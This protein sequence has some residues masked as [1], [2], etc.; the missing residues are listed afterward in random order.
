LFAFGAGAETST[1]PAISIQDLNTKAL[2]FIDKAKAACPAGQRHFYVRPRREDGGSGSPA[3]NELLMRSEI[4]D[5][6]VNEGSRFCAAMEDNMYRSFGDW[7]QRGFEGHSEFR[8]AV[9]RAAQAT[10]AAVITG[11]A[12]T[13]A[14]PKSTL[15]VTREPTRMAHGASCVTWM[16]YSYDPK[17]ELVVRLKTNQVSETLQGSEPSTI[18]EFRIP[19]DAQNF[20]GIFPTSVKGLDQESRGC[21]QREP[22]VDVQDCRWSSGQGCNGE[23]TCKGVAEGGRPVAEVRSEVQCGSGLDVSVAGGDQGSA[24]RALSPQALR[25]CI[26]DSR[27]PNYKVTY[28]SGGPGPL[29]RPEATVPTLG[30]A[31]R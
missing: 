9:D 13:R 7:R 30:G 5:S 1:V 20:L 10:P 31:A 14:N 17:G 26:R 16:S 4:N 24:C 15:Q 29:A 6:K 23:V 19:R 18:A 25:A 21:F 12:P 11:S 3:I 22:L 8:Q 2:P 27:N 28:S